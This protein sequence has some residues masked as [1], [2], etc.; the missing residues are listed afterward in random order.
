MTSG[1]KLG[2]PN[3]PMYPEY[4]PG[5]TKYRNLNYHERGVIYD[6]RGNAIERDVDADRIVNILGNT[7]SALYTNG[8]TS[9]VSFP[10]LRP[11]VDNGKSKV[12]CTKTGIPSLIRVATKKGTR[13]IVDTDSWNETPEAEVT[14]RMWDLFEHY[15][16]GFA[17]TAGSL[18]R[19]LMIKIHQEQGFKRHT[20]LSLS[21]EKFIK[22]NQPGGMAQT[23]ELGRWDQL[24]YI[25]MKSAYLS[26]YY[27]NPAGTARWEIGLDDVDCATYFCRCTV[28]VTSDLP[29]G[30]FAVRTTDWK[31]YRKRLIYPR[32]PGVYENV[33]LWKEQVETI[34]SLGCEVWTHEG[35]S[36][37]DFTTDNMFW[38]QS[39]F[40]LRKSAGSSHVKEKVKTCIVAPIGRMGMDRLH[41]YLVNEAN[42]KPEDRV[43]V[44]S[45][46]DPIDI[47][48][49]EE[50]D[51]NSAYMTHWWAYTVAMCNLELFNFAYPFALQGKLVST[52][53]D[54]VLVKDLGK[55]NFVEYG[56]PQANNAKPGT[57]VHRPLHEIEVI[58]DRSFRSLELTK[59]PGVP[60]NDAATAA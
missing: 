30:P 4:F 46:G 60:H 39:S 9:S 24:D 3:R 58:A 52:D 1:V 20:S 11:F 36:W 47:Y 49:R 10:Y 33:Y 37:P 29:L 13:W 28:F 31:K 57:W 17:P 35:Y 25:D 23:L 27:M 19:L 6:H 22:D 2:R 7:N 43:M 51:K 53:Y 54:S 42:H 5:E 8:F 16:I 14:G 21:C 44:D 34:R 32:Q 45:N 40:W 12:I 26:K 15:G 48:I 56:T 59:T 38:C 50:V 18:G 55:H 41:Y